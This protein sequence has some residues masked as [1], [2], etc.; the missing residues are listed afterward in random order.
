LD[1]TRGALVLADLDGDD[2]QDAVVFPTLVADLGL[3]PQGIEGAVLIYHGAP[4][5][6]YVLAV[7]PEIFGQPAPLVLDDLNADGRTDLAWT[8]TS[9]STFCV[10][11]VQ[12]VTWDAATGA[13]SSLVAPGATIAEGEAHFAPVASG[14]PGA[15]RQL[16]LSGGV[17]GA[18]DGGLAVPHTE[19]WQSVNGAPYARRRWE[20]DRSAQ[21]SDCLGLRLVEADMALQASGIGGFGPAQA[22]YAAALDDDL[23][24]CSLFDLPAGEEL[25]LLYGLARFRL[26]QS[27]ALGADLAGAGAA[28][29]D[30]QTALPQSLYTQA[31][32][33]WL[34]AID[35]GSTPAAACA[36]VAPIF[37][38][39][40][41]LWQVTDHFGYNHPALAAEQICYVPG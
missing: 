35:G 2:V 28:L 27:L 12:G 40:S 8:V 24:A 26:I 30:M 21:Q 17:S 1:A 31:A 7:H 41:E 32:G 5:G 29:A 3:G 9:C 33:A 22:L 11:E 4:D 16:V 23:A 10:V 6:S 37:V 19:I 38:D 34:E 20:Y 18:A 36:A 15:G 25:D 39:N 14:D 13:Y